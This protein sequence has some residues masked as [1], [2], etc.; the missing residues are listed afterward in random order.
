MFSINAFS[1]NQANPVSSHFSGSYKLMS[2]VLKDHMALYQDE[3]RAK[4]DYLTLEKVIDARSHD[5]Q[6]LPDCVELVFSTQNS[7]VTRNQ[8]L[9]NVEAMQH[10]QDTATIKLITRFGEPLGE[11]LC[12][13]PYFKQ[14]LDRQ[15]GW[16]N[17][18]DP[19]DYGAVCAALVDQAL[20]RAAWLCQVYKPDHG[21]PR[22]K[23]L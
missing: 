17:Q 19:I 4:N 9:K 8:P 3:E 7:G 6:A 5:I 1:M 22:E 21:K 12:A 20:Q 2:K 16:M 23:E 14:V 13:T 18:P 10:Y 11:T 15:H